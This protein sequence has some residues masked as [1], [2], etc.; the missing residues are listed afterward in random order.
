MTPRMRA[1]S[2]L[3]L[4]LQQLLQRVPLLFERVDPGQVVAVLLAARAGVAGVAVARCVQSS[5]DLL[6]SASATLPRA[7]SSSPAIA[8]GLPLAV[9]RGASASRSGSSSSLELAARSSISACAA[10][11]S[12]VTSI[13]TVRRLDQLGRGSVDD[14]AVGQVVDLAVLGDQL[15]RLAEQEEPDAALAAAAEVDAPAVRRGVD[16]QT[17]RARAEDA[18]QRLAARLRP[19]RRDPRLALGVDHSWREPALLAAG[20]SVSVPI[21]PR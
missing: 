17:R 18:A 15:D 11:I 20:R 6:A 8:L 5:R 14:L 1:S 12:S 13:V 2:A 4:A 21:R 16:D 10:T 3:G 9:L 7:S 19:G